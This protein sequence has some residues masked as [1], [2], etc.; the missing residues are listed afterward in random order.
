MDLK[1]TIAVLCN[2]RLMPERV[3][4]MDRF[5]WLFDKAC[6][7]QGHEV[8][9]FFP[10]VATHGHY[11]QLQIVADDHGRVEQS[12]LEHNQPFDIVFTHFV[13]ICTPFYQAVKHRYKDTKMIAVDHNPRP[14]GGY[15]LSKK[16]KKRLKGFFYSR[17][18]DQFVGVSEYTV[19]ELFKD[20]GASIQS[21]TQVIY[22]GIETTLYKK[23][24]TRAEAKPT[25][26]VASH[27]RF[28]KGIQDL[29]E[30]VFLLP[31]TIKDDL[32][33]D[34]YGEGPYEMTLK[35]LIKSANLEQQFIFKGSVANLYDIYAEYDY[36]IH[37]SHEETFCFS[38]VESMICNV[39]ALTTEYPGGNVLR[40]ITDNH[41]GL[42]FPIK[43]CQKLSKIIENLY[44]GQFKIEGDVSIAIIE[45]FT[46]ENMVKQ[47][48]NLI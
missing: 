46:I 11:A 2:Y 24:L 29:I 7:Q 12:F 22:N 14:L 1:K 4:G 28:S 15:P 38:V 31:P 17:Y 35:T 36:L 32:K 26:M 47:Y 10:N 13:E 42:L 9:W 25:F 16:I 33:I 3:G 40:L 19:Q 6:K 45:K 37:T 8:V 44:L 41:N 34:L 18:V 27:L 21:K 39:A 23:R 30:A 48:L 43:D 20:F 5:F